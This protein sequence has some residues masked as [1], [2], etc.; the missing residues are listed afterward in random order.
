MYYILGPHF[1]STDPHQPK[2]F[3]KCH[4]N[5]SQA[6]LFYQ[7]PPF[8]TK[9]DLKLPSLHGPKSFN[10]LGPIYL[11]IYPKLLNKEF[12]FCMI[13]INLVKK[14]QTKIE[15]NLMKSRWP[16]SHKIERE[17]TDRV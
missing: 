11:T 15:C 3:D 9:M 7:P 14:D 10:N 13:R 6:T 4:K 2:S 5:D 17:W 8:P 1:P 12:P 16:K